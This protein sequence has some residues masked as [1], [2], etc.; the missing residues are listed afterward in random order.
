MKNYSIFAQLLS[1]AAF[2]GAITRPE[3]SATQIPSDVTK[4]GADEIVVTN[5]EEICPDSVAS[6]CGLVERES[7]VR[8]LNSRTFDSTGN[9]E[10]Y[11][12]GATFFDRCWVCFRPE[13]IEG[14]CFALE[15]AKSTVKERIFL[16]TPAPCEIY[17]IPFYEKTSFDMSMCTDD[18]ASKCDVEKEIK[19][20]SSRTS[21]STGNLQSYENGTAFLDKCWTCLSEENLEGLCIALE[22]TKSTV[23]ERVFLTM[24]DLCEQL[25]DTSVCSSECDIENEVKNLSSR[26]SASIGNLQ[27][28]ENGT[29]FLDK[30]QTC[31]SEENLEAFCFAL[32]HAKSTVKERV[33]LPT[34]PA[35]E[36]L[37]GSRSKSISN[38]QAVYIQSTFNFDNS[39][40]SWCLQAKNIR[41]NAKLNVMPCKGNKKQKWLFEDGFLFLSEKPQFCVMNIKGKVLKLGLCSDRKIAD[42]TFDDSNGGILALKN[43]DKKLYFGFNTAKMYDKVR[44]YTEEST[45]ESLFLWKLDGV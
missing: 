38:G 25:R 8:T 36:T 14:F 13:N 20:L 21:A 32:D 24:P 26:T 1:I 10:S 6:Q 7:H 42:F 23:R 45:N 43:G 27:S 15:H 4:S 18:M 3:V 28:Y 34:P 19:N 40:T 11:Q 41:K 35:C 22:H 44:L 30:C 29:A 9:L 17:I 5:R 33:F 31:L 12:L 39:D 16:P 2:I 37:L